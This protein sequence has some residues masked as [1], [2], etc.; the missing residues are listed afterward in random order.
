MSKENKI[1]ISVVIPAYNEEK[2]I[3]AC[4]DSLKKQSFP[5]LFY[6]VIVVDN[7]STDKTAEIAKKFQTKVILETERGT[8]FA[9]RKGLNQAQ[10]DIVALTDADTI[11]NKDWLKNIYQAFENNPELVLVGGRTLF[12]PKVPLSVISQG[13]FNLANGLIGFNGANGA[14]RKDTY[15]RVYGIDEKINLSWETDLSLRLKKEGQKT[16]LIRN[17]VI[18]SSRHFR[19]WHG[20]VYCL[21][22][23]ANTLGVVFLKKS[24]FFYFGEVR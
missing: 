2:H 15:Q 23:I 6:E 9:I 18:T 16:F 3:E 17:W 7:D 19:G 4:L 22:G 8:V 21:K 20:I 10:G 12:R 11:V 14:I 5:K 24:F 1:L 13:I